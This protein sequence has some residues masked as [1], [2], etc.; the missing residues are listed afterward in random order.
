MMM[1]MKET[2]SLA[3]EVDDFFSQDPSR[4]SD[5]FMTPEVGEKTR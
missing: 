1:M 3:I 2:G 5:G 4:E